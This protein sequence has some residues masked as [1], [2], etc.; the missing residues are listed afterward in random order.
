[1]RRLRYLWRAFSYRWRVNRQELAFLPG[2]VR[3]G[4]TVVDIGAHKGGFLYWLRRHV[5]ASGRVYA[6]EPQPGLAAYLKEIVAMQGW[7]NVTVESAALSSAGG[8]MDLFVPA[9]EGA[10][11][12]G[13][14]LS[15]ADR[16]QPH[17]RIPVPVVALD[18]YLERRGSPRVAFI[19]CDVEGHESAVFEGA[20]KVLERDHPVLVFECEQ[21]HLPGSSPSAV[22]EYLRGLGYRGYLF[23]TSGL[24]PVAE[25]SVARHQPVRP[26]RYWDEKDYFNNFV[27]LPEDTRRD[28]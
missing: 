19:K 25:F 8:T 26:G 15:P 4:D 22:F 13:A 21:R 28:S 11:S 1:M 27:F 17:H 16:G 2:R 12:P 3:A 5:T 6:F 18:D 9:A 20:R 14:S 23:H 24:L 7:D 10:P